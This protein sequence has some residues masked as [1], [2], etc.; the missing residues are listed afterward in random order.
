M[1]ISKFIKVDVDVLLE[2]IYDDD[3]YIA[4]DYRMVIDTLRD[5]RAF[6][7]TEFTSVSPN[8]TNND[9]TKQ[10]FSLDPTINKWGVVDPSPD[11]NRYTFMQYQRFPGN[12]PH[13]YDIVRLHFPI[14]YTFK[15]KLGVLVNIGLL[16]KDQQKKYNI[17]NY[18]YDKSDTSRSVLEVTLATTPFLFQEQLWGKYIEISVPS[19]YA[20]VNDAE[21][22]NNTR[23]PRD[24]GIHKNLV[25]DDA[26][27]LSTETPIFV[28]FS[29]LTKTETILNQKS[30]LTT[31][32]F[33][34]TIPIT[35]E[36]EQL[37]MNVVP[38]DQGDYFEIYGT[39]NNTISEFE[40]FI[41]KERHNGKNYY[42]LFDV[43]TFEKNIKTNIV[44]YSKFDNF[45]L[46]I[47]FRPIIKFS[48][49]TATID[50]TMKLVDAI[51]DSIILRRGSYSMLQEDAAKYSRNL[52]KIDI[53]DTYK[54]KVYNAKPDQINL[55]IGE[56]VGTGNEKIV[57]VPFAVMYER[58]NILTKNKTEDVNDSTFYGI[59]QQQILLYPQNN[60]I[61]LAIGKGTNEKGVIPFEIPEN[62]PVY[63]QF[64][65]NKKLVE[66][67]LFYESGEVNLVGGIVVFN[68]LESQIDILREIKKDG[69]DQFYI[70]LKSETG[71][72]SVVY[73]GKYLIYDEN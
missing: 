41:E 73:P 42:V 51:D 13:R 55:Q 59:G 52:T 17:S 37:G 43:C 70:I 60:V 45:N 18:Y 30:Y 50:V 46:P 10:L 31:T 22:I 29:F 68:I 1:R 33:S 71:I 16:S 2:W 47:D 32:P 14:N 27:V 11:T 8:T 61:K 15:D 19:P 25:E 57:N 21:I 3:N 48:T 44:T 24:G 39:F 36:F 58:Y 56:G 34:A 49:T 12:V 20:L 38:S 62:T 66:V 72:N 69:F 4:Q 6:S 53:R 9:T 54:P 5:T 67:P 23:V 28:D 35:P 65:S 40:N 7:Q 26:G 63:I 64:K